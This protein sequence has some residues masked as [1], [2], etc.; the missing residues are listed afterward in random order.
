LWRLSKDKSPAEETLLKRK[1]MLQRRRLE[2]MKLRPICPQDSCTVM[3][4]IAERQPDDRSLPDAVSTPIQ[5]G[6][7]ADKLRG[8][9][10]LF[11]H[12][13]FCILR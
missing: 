4:A 7:S 8:F 11:L 10:H 2:V 12:R 6:T 3:T 5:F 1:D 13:P 9:L